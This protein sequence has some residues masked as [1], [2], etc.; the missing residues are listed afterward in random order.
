MT[1]AE[2]I[3]AKNFSRKWIA[4]ITIILEAPSRWPKVEKTARKYR[5]HRFPYGVIYVV[6]PAEIV[7]IAMTHLHR[8]P[9]YWRSRVQLP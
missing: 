6:N 9:G 1:R 3:L 8:S 2:Q 5:L 7:I 4:A